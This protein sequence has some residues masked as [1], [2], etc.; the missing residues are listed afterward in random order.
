MKKSSLKLG[1]FPK[2]KSL[3]DAEISHKATVLLLLRLYMISFPDL[4]DQ[5]AGLPAAQKPMSH[6]FIVSHFTFRLTCQVI[7]SWHA[8]GQK[9]KY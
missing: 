6:A 8:T 2:S 3:C 1:S 5:A 9:A 4:G 7:V